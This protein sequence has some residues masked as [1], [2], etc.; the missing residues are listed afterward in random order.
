ML[1]MIDLIRVKYAGLGLDCLNLLGIY[2]R[3]GLLSVR[4]WP[5]A[6]TSLGRHV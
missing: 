6:L 3:L 2:V 4:A 1:D 5:R